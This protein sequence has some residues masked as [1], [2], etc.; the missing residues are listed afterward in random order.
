MEAMDQ[1]ALVTGVGKPT[2]I[3]FEVCKQL[4]EIGFTVILSARRKAAAESLASQI[5]GA[6]PLELDL[7]SDESI[8]G[9]SR[10]IQRSTGRLDVLVN[11]AAG[12]GPY[13]ETVVNAD[14]VA[15]SNLLDTTLYGTWA[16]IQELLP[17][18]QSSSAGRIVNVSSGAG[19]F[20][21]QAFGVQTQNSMG[22]SYAISKA[23]LNVLTVKLAQELAETPILVNAVCPGF[24]AT[25]PG[26]ETMGARPVAEGAKG[27]VW[28]AT[29]PNDGPR[30][31]FFRDGHPL[32][33]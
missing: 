7:E 17:F 32:G 6:I 23:A 10:F 22:V 12:V 13:G 29:L 30:G 3:G 5:P 4:A 18:L 26:A 27:I 25:F 11:N 9:A 21:D 16:L 8:S 20:S 1:V 15:S 19:S 33:W 31:G 14:L 2:G 28:A 24:T